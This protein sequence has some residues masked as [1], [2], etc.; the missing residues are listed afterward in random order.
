MAANRKIIA[1]NFSARFEFV[2]LNPQVK[3]RAST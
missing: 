3:I 1:G 2:V